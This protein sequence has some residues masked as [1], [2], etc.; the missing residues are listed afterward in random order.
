[1]RFCDGDAV[2]MSPYDQPYDTCNTDKGYT[3]LVDK[4][5]VNYK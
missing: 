4:K 1:M 3:L 2:M 5:C